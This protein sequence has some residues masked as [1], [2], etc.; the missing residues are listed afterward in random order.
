MVDYIIENAS[1]SV[2]ARISD[3]HELSS[4]KDGLAHAWLP[5]GSTVTVLCQTHHAAVEHGGLEPVDGSRRVA[6]SYRNPQFIGFE[7]RQSARIAVTL[8][9]FGT[10]IPVPGAQIVFTMTQDE[11]GEFVDDVIGTVETM[12]DGRT[13]WIRGRTGT[14]VRAD[15]VSLPHEFLGL[16]SIDRVCEQ[17]HTW[18]LTG[19]HMVHWN[20]PRKPRVCVRAHDA[21]SGERIVG[22]HY[23]V[24]MR[25]HAQRPP[26]ARVSFGG[27]ELLQEVRKVRNAPQGYSQTATVCCVSDRSGLYPR[28]GSRHGIMSNFCFGSSIVRCYQH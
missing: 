4:D 19:E 1:P 17:E 20:V 21:A 2:T 14:L 3:R 9:E 27:A 16:D 15:I 12:S 13:P 8:R 23:R 22:V 25:R 26:G 5:P 28:C 6:I 10:N 18:R 11:N 7:L 24:M